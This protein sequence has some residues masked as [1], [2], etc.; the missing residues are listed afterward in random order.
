MKIRQIGTMVLATM[1][2]A[3]CSVP[4]T[5]QQAAS[6][7]GAATTDVV[8][9]TTARTTPTEAAASSA[10]ASTSPIPSTTATTKPSAS[11]AKRGGE[12]GRTR[13]W[14]QRRCADRNA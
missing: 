2:L 7:S 4:G 13:A 9:A 5:P 3:A 10:A 8:Q 1:V 12:F 6:P 11:A 14:L